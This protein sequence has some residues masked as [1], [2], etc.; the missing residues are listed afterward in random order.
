MWN[1]IDYD[2]RVLNFEN[3][4]FKIPLEYPVDM[5]RKQFDA[6]EFRIDLKANKVINPAGITERVSSG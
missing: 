6:Y 1:Q 4:K 3:A 2:N 5:P